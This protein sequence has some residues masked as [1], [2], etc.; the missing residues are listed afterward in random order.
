MN[1][2]KRPYLSCIDYTVSNKKFDLLYNVEYDMLET[3]P[4]P[5][6]DEL[7]MYYES[8]DYISHTDAKKSIVDKLYQIVKRYALN[9]KLELINSFKTSEKTLLDIGCGTG[10]FLAICKNN[11]WK[12]EGVEPNK[13]A[14][15]LAESKVNKNDVAAIFT[16]IN[17][18]ESE[19]FDVITLWHVLEHVPNLETYISKL[20]SLL[21]PKG[22]LVVAVPNF[23]SYDALY[24]KQFWAAFDVPRH[25]WHFS[26]TAI[27]KLFKNEHMHVEI[28]L[29]MKFDSF[30]VSLLSE[31]YKTSNSNFLKAFYVG[32]KSNLKAMAS[33]EYSSLIYIIKNG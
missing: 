2:K 27:Q 32:L 11:G 24:Y 14:R 21:K 6:G 28:M 7:D 31:K 13:N 20:K 8:L 25:L 26:K 33:K 19:K 3:F 4:Q 18:L 1:S 22:V 5:E 10:D 15:K 9:K 29:P 23:K 12:V 30:Y 16:N 17:E